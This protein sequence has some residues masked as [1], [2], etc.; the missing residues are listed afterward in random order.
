MRYAVLCYRRRL[1][2][3]SPL[4][5]KQSLLLIALYL[6]RQ[7]TIINNISVNWFVCCCCCCLLLLFSSLT[8]VSARNIET[9]ELFREDFTHLKIVTTL[10]VYQ[11]KVS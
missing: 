6:S 3:F 2:R 9:L 11:R 1:K 10:R 4:T 7:Q 8:I 5:F